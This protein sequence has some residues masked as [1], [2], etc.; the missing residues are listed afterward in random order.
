M[1]ESV[2]E[3][4]ERERKWA[5]E[6]GSEKVMKALWLAPGCGVRRRETGKLC[7]ET[8]VQSLRWNKDFPATVGTH[9]MPGL[10]IRLLQMSKQ[11]TISLTLTG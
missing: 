1:K 11:K 2:G 6:S 10:F 3:D 9:A 4:V 7:G 5:C 8:T